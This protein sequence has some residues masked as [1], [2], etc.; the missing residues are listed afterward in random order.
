M[1]ERVWQYERG[2][3]GTG[4]GVLTVGEEAIHIRPGLRGTVGRAFGRRRVDGQRA[5]RDT[6]RL[7]LGA[8]GIVGLGV[9]MLSPVRSRQPRPAALSLCVPSTTGVTLRVDLSV[10]RVR[11]AVGERTDS[12]DARERGVRVGLIR[13]CVRILS[14][15]RQFEAFRGLTQL[16]T[17]SR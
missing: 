5:Q 13:S 15:P 1:V 10:L 6:G 17:A 4:N 14:P 16:A 3:F 2:W 9:A 7:S 11:P 12:L 8:A